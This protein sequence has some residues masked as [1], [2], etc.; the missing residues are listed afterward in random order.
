MG[1]PSRTLWAV[2]V[3]YDVNDTDQL[4]ILAASTATAGTK[5]ERFLRARGDR[6]FEIVEIKSEGTIDVF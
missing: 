3:Q 6:G 5:A 1:K 2:T 4:W